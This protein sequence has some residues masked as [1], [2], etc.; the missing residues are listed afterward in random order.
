V[1]PAAGARSG[2]STDNSTRL[3]RGARADGARGSTKYD[4]SA[5][6]AASTPK[7]DDD[8]AKSASPSPDERLPVRSERGAAKGSVE[9]KLVGKLPPDAKLG[10]DNARTAGENAPRLADARSSADLRPAAKAP[11][12][13]PAAQKSTAEKFAGDPATGETPDSARTN[14]EV[15]ASSRALAGTSTPSST[16]AGASRPA[17]VTLEEPVFDS[18][19]VPRAAASLERMKNAFARCASAENALTKNEGKSEGSVDLRF[20]VRAPGRA[21]GVGA[22]KARGLSADVVRC[23]T[24]VL[25]RSYIGAPSDDPVGVAVTVR[26][27]KD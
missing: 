22:D 4:P 7:Q 17:V 10:T 6:A 16:A 26:V 5:R 11:I 14:A 19:E 20:L 18:G 21:E 12:D 15:G 25:A 23:M 1:E 2:R 9:P 24:T 3:L 8:R 13:L 27:R